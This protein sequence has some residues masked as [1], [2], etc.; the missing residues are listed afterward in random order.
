MFVAYNLRRLMNIVN[1][2]VLKRF[3]G[4]PGLLFLKKSVFS[5]ETKVIRLIPF[6][7]KPKM[8]YFLRAA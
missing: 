8:D 1:K 5:D 3:F 6:F 7:E 2:N 4:E